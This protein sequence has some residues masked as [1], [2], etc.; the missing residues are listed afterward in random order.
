[1]G[2]EHQTVIFPCML[3]IIIAT[4]FNPASSDSMSSHTASKQET[5]LSNEVRR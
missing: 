3:L 2:S 5:V 4:G 1:M